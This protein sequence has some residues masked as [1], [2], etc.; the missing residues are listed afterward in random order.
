[1]RLAIGLKKFEFSSILAVIAL[2]AA[3]NKSEFLVVKAKLKAEKIMRAVL[4]SL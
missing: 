2:T 3:L 1:M 4:E